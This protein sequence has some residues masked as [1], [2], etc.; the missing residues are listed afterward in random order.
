MKGSFVYLN[1][2]RNRKIN[3]VSDLGPTSWSLPSILSDG[4]SGGPRLT[5]RGTRPET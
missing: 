4:W 2:G 1:S 3:V 5:D